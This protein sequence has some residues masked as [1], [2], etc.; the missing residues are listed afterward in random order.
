M[1][2]MAMNLEIQIRY[3]RRSLIETITWCE[4]TPIRPAAIRFRSPELNPGANLDPAHY[5]STLVETVCHRRSQLL[6][7]WKVPLVQELGK[8]G[9]LLV[10]YPGLSLFDGA[11]ELSSDGYFNSQNE[12]PWD[13]WVFFGETPQSL[14]PGDY[15][16]FL[17]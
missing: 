16:F 5:S 8:E 13:T 14:E 1:I 7:E 11:A 10:F 2:V 9:R 3:L 17:L 12:P 4:L 6:K 15:H